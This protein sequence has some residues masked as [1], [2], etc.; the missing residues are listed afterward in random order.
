MTYL[1]LIYEFIKT[2]LFAIGGGMATIPF[3]HEVALKYDW[4]NTA[5]LVDMIAISESTPG[6][7]GVNMATFAGFEAAGVGGAVVSTLA[8]VFPSYIIIMIIAG[9][10]EKFQKNTYVQNSFVGLRPAVVGLLTVAS[11]AIF[12]VS[13]FTE[14]GKTL[15]QW[16]GYFD[17]KA[18]VVF[19]L[20]LF[21]VMKLKKHPII[22]I[23][24]GAVA[25]IVLQTYF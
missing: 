1:Y 13:F 12:K 16:I 15:E 24:I 22:Y 14:A 6:P 2:G 8:L 19:A 23:G 11:V 4:F 5:D 21:G 7:I 10:M 20:L 18:F 17:Y 3:L 9:M 25:G